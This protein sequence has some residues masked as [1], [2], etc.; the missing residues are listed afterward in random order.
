MHK[1][2]ISPMRAYCVYAGTLCASRKKQNLNSGQRKILI[3]IIAYTLIWN[4]QYL[5]EYLPGLFDMGIILTLMITIVVL[6]LIGIYQIYK[7]VSEEQKIKFR[8]INISLIVLVS[9]LTYFK[10]LGLIDFKIFEGEN[11]LYAMREGV[12]NCTTSIRLKEGN[13]FKKTSICFGIDH[14]WGDYEIVNDTIK[15]NYDKISEENGRDDF[16]I[17][18]ITNDTTDKR[19]GVIHYHSEGLRKE[20]MPMVIRELKR[21]KL[22][23]K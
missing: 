9:V 6:I 4:S 2:A 3:A 19:L 1:T 22:K 13:R 23:Q 10:P 7:Y 11:V 21:E 5:W 15:F 14:Y 17:V 20:G 12:A 8:L 16:A 18:Q